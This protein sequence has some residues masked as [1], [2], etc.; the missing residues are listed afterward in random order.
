MIS[1]LQKYMK[2][3]GTGVPPG[4]GSGPAAPM[5]P[6]IADPY[7]EGEFAPELANP[8]DAQNEFDPRRRTRPYMGDTGAAGA[9]P[10]PVGRG[11]Y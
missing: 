5:G 6:G 2:Q 9:P 4:I 11:G 1:P 3:N 8:Q 7:G 10:M